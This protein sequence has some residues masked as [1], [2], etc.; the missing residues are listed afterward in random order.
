MVRALLLCAMLFQGAT[1]TALKAVIEN[2]R[3]IVWDVTDP[4]TAQPFDSVVVSLSGKAAFLPKGTASNLAGRSILI[5]LKD[6]QSLPSPIPP[7]IHSRFLG[8]DRRRSSKTS[9]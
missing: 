8:L 9:A 7:A 5:D 1:Q 6:H 2:D 3:V 4:T